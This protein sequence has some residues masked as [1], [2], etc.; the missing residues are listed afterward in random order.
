[1]TGEKFLMSRLLQELLSIHL[2]QRGLKWK[3]VELNPAERG[4]GDSGAWNELVQGE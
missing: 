1:M 2:S 3:G 4:P